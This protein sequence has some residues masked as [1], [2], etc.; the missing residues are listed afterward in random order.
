MNWLFGA[1]IVISAG[2]MTHLVITLFTRLGS[3]RP[4]IAHLERQ[5]SDQELALDRT[6]G[7]IMESEH[8]TAYLEEE[9]LRYERRI[10]DLQI[11]INRQN[12]T[13]KQTLRESEKAQLSPKARALTG[14]NPG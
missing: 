9:A 2:Y 11:R 5:I 14:Q 3:L 8:K 4:R 12:P 13:D 6:E 7:L 10:S 1:I